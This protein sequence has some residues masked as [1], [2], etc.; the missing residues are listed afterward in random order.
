MDQLPPNTNRSTSAET[1]AVWMQPTHSGR[2]V[3]VAKASNQITALNSPISTKLGPHVLTHKGNE[4]AVAFF[5][6][7]VGDPVVV[8]QWLSHVRLFA[9]P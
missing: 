5:N 9:T 8:I 3:W 4:Q 6:F 7:S 1:E 2:L